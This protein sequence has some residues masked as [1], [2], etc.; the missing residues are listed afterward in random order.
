MK[1]FKISHQSSGF[2]LMEVALALAIMGVLLTPILLLQYNVLKRVMI[3]KK[4]LEYL[5][6]LKPIAMSILIDPL[7][8]DETTQ[9]KQIDDPLMK[10]VYKKVPVKGSE[11][12]RFKDLFLEEVTGTWDQWDKQKE[13]KLINLL[14]V[15]KQP[16]KKKEQ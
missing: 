14:F 12:S 11:L 6:P 15:P 16:E 2:M 13:E 3:N 7:K 8:E 4:K 10:V 9:E 1:N 5:L